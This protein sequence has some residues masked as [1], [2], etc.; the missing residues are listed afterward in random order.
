MK[1]RSNV[2]GAIIT[3]GLLWTVPAALQ[4]A[5]KP[6]SDSSRTVLA[7]LSGNETHVQKLAFDVQMDGRSIGE[8]VVTLT[9][10]ANGTDVAID[11]DIEVTFGPF[12]L[13]KYEQQN[14]AR[15][16]GE[17]LAAFRSVTN[18]DGDDYVVEANRTEQG[19]A[20]SVNGE[21]TSVL[22]NW[23]PTTYWDKRTVMQNTLVATQDGGLLDV[24]INPAGTETLNVLGMDTV[25]E[26]YE[27]RGDLEL[28]LWYDDQDRWVKLA[29]SYR[30]NTFEYILR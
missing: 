24:E 4:A 22:P 21:A 15:W 28:D 14:R 11:V 23:F 8:H 5:D 13:Y 3:A 27:M 16:A 30:G 2:L 9:H 19:L 12:T 10:R 26:K 20:V 29:F 17:E 1:N 18:D 7:A 6:A 25:A